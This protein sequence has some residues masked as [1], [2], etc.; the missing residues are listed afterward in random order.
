M[1]IALEHS[2]I[3]L[4]ESV[5]IVIFFSVFFAACGVHLLH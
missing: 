4:L 3:Y 1:F 5:L 2:F